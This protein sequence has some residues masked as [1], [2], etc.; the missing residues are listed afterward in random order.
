MYVRTSKP[1]YFHLKIHIMYMLQR[2][3]IFSKIAHR[4]KALT[5]FQNF[6][7]Q[8]HKC[9]GKIRMKKKSIGETVF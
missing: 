6:N 7:L 8:K 9:C 5:I 3:R 2:P 4:I 1:K